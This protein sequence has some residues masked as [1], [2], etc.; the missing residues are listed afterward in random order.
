MS[1]ALAEAPEQVPSVTQDGPPAP[2]AN[3]CLLHAPPREGRPWVTADPGYR[4][5]AGCLD[6]VRERLA[7]VRDRWE[8]LD[9]RP[10]A[11]GEAGG[12]GAPGFGSRPPASDHVIAVR[13]WRSS[14]DARVWLAADGRV[15]RESE[16][17]PLSVL[18][19]LFTLARHVAGARRLDGPRVLS[20][21]EIARWLDGQLDWITRQDGVGAFDRVLRE[22][23]AQ[24]RPLTG[25]PGAKRVG[26]CPNTL[27]TGASTVECGAP[28]Y[29]P[30]RGDTISCRAC[31]R[32]WT[33]D[34]WLELGRMLQAA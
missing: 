27:D 20:V 7:E 23:V 5:C 15:H 2:P 32:D 9:P 25:E 11:Q 22:L 33:R 24:L 8:V 19:E 34:Q 12:R 21:A 18:A 1:V 6:R 29:A 4:T 10:G 28:L 3:R 14:R 30:L 26:T 31:T 17:P 13:D 16:R